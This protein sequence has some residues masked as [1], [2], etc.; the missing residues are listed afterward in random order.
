MTTLLILQSINSKPMARDI[1]QWDTDSGL[2]GIVNIFSACISHEAEDFIWEL[3]DS[4][5]AIKGLE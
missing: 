5:I 2:V 1:P 3:I 4:N